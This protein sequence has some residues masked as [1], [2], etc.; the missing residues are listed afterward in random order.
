MA[1]LWGASVT[2]VSNKLPNRNG[3][4]T[5]PQVVDNLETASGLLLAMV[6]SEDAVPTV[7]WEFAARVV[8]TGA[9]ALTEAQDFPEQSTAKTS[10]A[11]VMWAQFIDWQMQVVK[12]VEALGGEPA[13]SERPAYNFAPPWGVQWSR[14]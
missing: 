4:L 5:E 14:F 13:V 2:G 11:S 12:G 3:K 8:E 9:A 6:G 10:L 7:L 1:V